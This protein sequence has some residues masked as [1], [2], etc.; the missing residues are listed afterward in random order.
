MVTSAI[1]TTASRSLGRTSTKT[2]L[3]SGTAQNPASMRCVLTGPLLTTQGSIPTANSSRRYNLVRTSAHSTPSTAAAS[4]SGG[5]TAPTGRLIAPAARCLL[6]GAVVSAIA[7]R[8]IYAYDYP[9]GIHVDEMVHLVQAWQRFT[10]RVPL[11]SV[12]N[13]G[14]GMPMALYA[15]VQGTLWQLVPAWWAIRLFGIVGGVLSVVGVFATARA[16]GRTTEGALLAAGCVS[17]L[18]WALVYGRSSMGGEIVWHECIATWALARCIWRSGGWRDAACIA[19]A[20]SLL[21]YDYFAGRALIWFVVVTVPLLRGRQRWLVAAAVLVALVAY[22]PAMLYVS[23]RTFVGLGGTMAAPAASLADRAWV[24][25]KSLA[26]PVASVGSNEHLAPQC[27][28][29]PPI[30]RL[31]HRHG[32]P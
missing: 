4:S 5:M 24:T 25:L 6:L 3:A 19:L 30:L 29:P 14:A 26:L 20:L 11:F 2:A 17:V 21:L 7:L 9:P 27:V 31:E 16:M 32:N 28:V 13:R 1:P 10:G 23:E 18:P 12:E 22:L 8:V 15:I